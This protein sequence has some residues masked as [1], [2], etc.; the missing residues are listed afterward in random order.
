MLIC[1][2]IIHGLTILT[3]DLAI[4]DCPIRSLW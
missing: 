3:P 1:Q 4:R 2:A